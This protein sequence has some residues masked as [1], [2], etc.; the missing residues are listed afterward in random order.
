MLKCL[1]NEHF[2]LLDESATENSND[3][4]EDN[5]VNLGRKSC[6]HQN[7]LYKTCPR[8]EF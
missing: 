4:K 6:T 2:S 7:P 3:D 5:V 1:L 8:K